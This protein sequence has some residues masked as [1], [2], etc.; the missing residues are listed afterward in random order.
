MKKMVISMDD[1]QRQF[2]F[3]KGNRP[4]N[5]KVVNQKEK[6][7]KAYGQ[8][9]PITVTNGEKVTQMGGRL[10]DLNGN[11]IPDEDAGK[12]YAVL[13]GQHRLIA[14]LKLG[15]N[16]DDLV[17]CEPLNAELSITEV[18]AQMNICTT[19]WKKSDYMA[20]PAMMLK[21]AN[22]V[23]DFAMFLH[24]KACPLATISLWCFGRKSLQAKDLVECLNTKKLPEIFEDKTWFRS[25]SRWFTSAQRIFKDKFLMN[26]YLI[27][28]IIKQQKPDEDFDRFTVEMEQKI[29]ALT[30]DQADQIMNP[31]PIKGVAREQLITDM[32]T[33]YLG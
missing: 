14:Y 16:L 22:E 4:V 13:D 25:S 23:F 20:A 5:S 10:V 8:L 17:I 9:T 12:Y 21:E 6:S 28:F 15:R 32:L 30:R 29:N 24:G 26:R 1:A 18:I 33:Q 19:V 11:E 31:R 3:V 2:A 27:D 7:M